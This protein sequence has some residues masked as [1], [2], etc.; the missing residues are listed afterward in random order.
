MN[1]R[2]REVLRSGVAPHL[3][4]WASCPQGGK[5]STPPAP[6][7]RGAAEAQSA[8]SKEIATQK[9]WADRPNQYTPWGSTTWSASPSVDPATGQSITTWNQFQNLNPTSQAAL[10]KQLGLMNYRTDLASQFAGRVGQDFGK[11]FD[12][13][14]LPEMARG[15]GVQDYGAQRQRIEEGLYAKM[16]P[17]H[18]GQEEQ[19]RTRLANQGLTPGSEAF[20][21]ELRNMR[22]S[23]ANERFN[24]MQTAG[25]EQQRLFGMDTEAAKFANLVRQQGISEQ[26]QQRNMSLNE[27]NA[28]LTGQ[29]VQAPGMP[30]FNAASAGQAP[31][32]LGAAQMQ[33][34]WDMDQAKAESESSAALWGG[35][36]KLAG[37]A[38]MTFSDIRLKSD[39]V[40][41]GEYLPGV[42][43]Y[44]YRIFGKPEVG[45]MAH[46]LLAVRPDLVHAHPSGYLM[47]DYGGL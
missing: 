12:W 31:N 25:Q 41:I 15:P 45:V 19:L 10:D 23:Q 22:E 7:Y 17:V 26:Q 28:L 44:S 2:L 30:S 9:T 27:L 4:H 36:G 21:S 29:Q 16:A 5:G 8:A 1:S 24:A 32:Y 43:V 38:M 13:T 3:A 37:T 11:P 47:V 40:K 20:E 34:Q 14:N 46:E 35:L 42:G 39:V 6:D 33:G 18:Q